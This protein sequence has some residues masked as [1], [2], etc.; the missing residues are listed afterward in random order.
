[1]LVPSRA[2]LSQDRAGVLSWS[3]D[4]GTKAQAGHIRPVL[5]S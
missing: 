3:A 5:P 1:M 4:E 2:M